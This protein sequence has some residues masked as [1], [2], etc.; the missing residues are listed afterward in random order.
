MC[1]NRRPRLHRGTEG[2]RKRR[3]LGDERRHRLGVHAQAQEPARAFVEGV[4]DAE[5]SPV[6]GPGPGSPGLAAGGL[7]SCKVYVCGM[8]ICIN[9]YVYMCFGMQ[10][11]H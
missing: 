10:N 3:G 1:V 5:G 9:V 11:R 4:A 6:P 2:A 7:G 8:Y